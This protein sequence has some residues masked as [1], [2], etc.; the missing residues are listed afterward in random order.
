MSERYRDLASL[1]ITRIENEL[2]VRD[3]LEVLSMRDAAALDPFLH[4]DVRFN[5]SSTSQAAGKAAV[6]HVCEQLFA[7]FPVYEV[8]AVAMSSVGRVVLVEEAVRVSIDASCNAHWLIGFASFEVVGY[9][10][11]SWRQLHG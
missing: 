3:F 10:I 11:V 2:L 5:G 7:N 4:P 1:G 6:L 8:Q 9:Q